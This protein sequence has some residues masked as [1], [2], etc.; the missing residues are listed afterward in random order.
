MMYSLSNNFSIRSMEDT[1]TAQE[2]VSLDL[3][4]KT[5]IRLERGG[6]LNLHVITEVILIQFYNLQ[7]NNMIQI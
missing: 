5:N 2:I 3:T 4:L 7:C 6:Q 1:L